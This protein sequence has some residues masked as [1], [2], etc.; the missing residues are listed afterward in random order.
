[1][2]FQNFSLYKSDT[3]LRIPTSPVFVEFYS[4]SATFGKTT[5]FELIWE[6]IFTA[7][8]SIPTEVG[9]TS[10]DSGSEQLSCST[11]SN[12]DNL[13]FYIMNPHYLDDSP[14]IMSTAQGT[15]LPSGNISVF[16]STKGNFSK[17]DR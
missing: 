6:F 13:N 1:L 3:P 4:D 14:I 12:E 5:G 15:T 17:L 9:F 11:D 7:G 8:V 16:G 10:N 2:K